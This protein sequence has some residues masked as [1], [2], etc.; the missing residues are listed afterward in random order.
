MESLDYQQ[1]F[2]SSKEQCVEY[3]SEPQ[4]EYNFQSLPGSNK[5]KPPPVYSNFRYIYPG[6]DI[7][8]DGSIDMRV[9][10]AIPY[11]M[12]L[13]E[14]KVLYMIF[15]YGAAEKEFETKEL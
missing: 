7:D 8:D 10:F 1:R 9:R 12:D 6:I 2:I 11:N 13:K 14:A 3:Q 5:V 4:P 15:P